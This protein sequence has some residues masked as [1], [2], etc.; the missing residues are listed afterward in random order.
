MNAALARG[1]S[2]ITRLVLG[3]TFVLAV[4]FM[5]MATVFYM[6]TIGVLDRGVDRKITAVASRLAASFSTGHPQ[7]LANA[8]NRELSDGSDSDTEIILA[9]SRGASRIAG[10]IDW[11]AELSTPSERFITRDVLHNG[12]AHRTRLL[13]QHLPE[14]VTLVVGRDLSEQENIQSMVWEALATGTG[15]AVLLGI[16]GALMF[17]TQLRRRIA[18]IRLTA[19]DIQEGDLS[20][21]IPASGDDEF[22]LLSDDINRMLDRIEQLMNGVRHVSNAIAHDLRTPLN[23][24]RSRLDD[25]LRSG[26]AAATLTESAEAAIAEID[27]LTQLFEKLLHIA[28]AESG[29]RT[30]QF[31]LVDLGRVAFDMVELYD[32]AAEECDCALRLVAD[33]AALSRGD[34]NLLASAVASLVDNAI[35]HAGPGATIVVSAYVV[36]SAA[37]IEVRDNGPGVPQNELAKVTQRFYRLDRSRSLPGNGLGL[38]IVSAIATLHAG[39]LTLESDNGMIARISL[40]AA[41]QSILQS[42]PN[43]GG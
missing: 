42:S 40:P 36:G 6:G 39:A 29:M 33:G 31:E 25:T 41:H 1:P 28:E 38:S 3:Y 16:V 12:T 37:T 11:F 24:I 27:E 35:K 21:R 15:A 4:S 26:A 8:I 2:V 7:M 14:G 34:R 43:A 19:K 9:Y 17:R 13:T 5:A 18:G 10:N 32:A 20:S 23:R 22:G 30:Q